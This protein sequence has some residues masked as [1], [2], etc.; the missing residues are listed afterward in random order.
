MNCYGVVCSIVLSK[1]L[2]YHS[3]CY[4]STCFLF[5]YYIP[6]AGKKFIVAKP[7]RQLE[8][9]GKNVRCAQHRSS[10]N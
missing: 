7:R 9:F 1:I 5:V 4:L 10:L 8:T 6:G 2:F 3:F